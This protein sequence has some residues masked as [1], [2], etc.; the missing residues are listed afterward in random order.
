MT[1]DNNIP[2]EWTGND[3]VSVDGSAPTRHLWTHHVDGPAP[4]KNTI[5][6]AGQDLVLL[7]LVSV[8]LCSVCIV[9]ALA[10]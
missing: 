3:S 8:I 6:I 10:S 2:P 9:I 1:E 7:L 5:S 4:T